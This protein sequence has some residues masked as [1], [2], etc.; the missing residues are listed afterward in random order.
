MLFG[1]A[2]IAQTRIIKNTLADF[3]NSSG[4]RINVA[5]SS[6][7]C[8]P[9]VVR[10]IRDGISSISGI[11]F[12][13]SLGSYLGVPLLKGRTKCKD[14]NFIL[15]K[16]NA[17]LCSWKNNLLNKAG[18]V[19]LAKAVLNA[20]PMY[21]MQSLWLLERVCEEIDKLNRR[22]I[23]GSDTKRRSLY[24]VSWERITQ[25]RATGGL[26]IRSARKTNTALL[27]KAVWSIATKENKLWVNLLRSKYGVDDV[28]SCNYRASD[29]YI[30]KGIIKA[31]N[32]L[33]NGFSMRIGDGMETALWSDIWV[34]DKPLIEVEGINQDL[35]NDR[36]A[37][38]SSIIENNKWDL[39]DLLDICPAKSGYHFLSN[40][41]S[42][43]GVSAP[44]KKLWKLRCPEKVKFF[45]WLVCNNSLPTNS[46][47]AKRGLNSSN[48]CGKCNAFEESILH[49][50]RDC[51]ED[52]RFLCILYDIWKMRNARVIEGKPL[53][54]TKFH[55][56][57]KS[58]MECVR[59]W[60]D[61]PPEVFSRNNISIGWTKPVEGYVKLNTDGSSIGN[62]GPMGIGGIFRNSDGGWLLGFSSFVGIQSNM[63]AELN[64]IKHGLAIAVDRKISK[65]EVNSDCLEAINL[66]TR[67]DISNHHLGVLIYDI[68]NL[69]TKFEAISVSHVFREAN[70]CADGLAKLGSQDR[71]EFRILDSPLL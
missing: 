45:V 39:Q 67:E 14:F 57:I 30:W 52:I 3:C 61:N 26:G 43:V 12:S 38:V 34:E 46:L 11:K 63:F 58:N 50:M 13:E 64:A 1:Q 35:I 31:K 7:I 59:I 36:S 62:P 65:L 15:Q 42:R 22:F 10:S 33:Q 21:T 41:N 4:L 25:P 32:I 40:N 27:G 51:A 60:L 56:D 71:M 29:S 68:R 28:L 17:R 47:R 69:M 5:K 23:C 66:I 9:R 49:C 8:S 70:H 19:T 18:R 24:L 48:V 16:L 54:I 20:I 2:S 6:A 37:K 44:W 53:N 55:W